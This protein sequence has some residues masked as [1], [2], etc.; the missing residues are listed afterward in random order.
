MLYIDIQVPINPKN[1]PHTW[2]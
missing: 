1:T 2:K